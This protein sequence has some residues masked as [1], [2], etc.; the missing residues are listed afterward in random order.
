MVARFSPYAVACVL[1]PVGT[2]EFPQQL[3][4]QRT[5]ICVL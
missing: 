3:A 4:V 2:A 5:N 1:H